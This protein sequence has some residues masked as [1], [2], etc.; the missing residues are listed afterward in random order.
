MYVIHYEGGEIYMKI[1][2]PNHDCMIR[3]S[4][5]VKGDMLYLY[6]KGDFKDVMY[7]LTYMVYGD[8]ECYYCHR[9]LRRHESQN[10]NRKYFSK[11][12][13]DHLIP[14]DFGGPTLPNNMRPACTACNSRKGN[15]FEDEYLEFLRIQDIVMRTG[16]QELMEKFKQEL[17]ERQEKRRKGDIPC[18]PQ[19]W[20]A[21]SSLKSMWVNYMVG[22]KKGGSYAQMVSDVE[23]YGCLIKTITCTANNVLVDGFNANLVS[24]FLEVPAII[25]PVDNMIHCGYPY[26]ERNT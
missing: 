24:T 10:D 6:K 14:Q 2:L 9:K 21:D 5:E 8:D 23:N 19:E 3:D 11:I 26:G 22:Q 25:I 13:M 15:M 12:S 1:P 4:A 20:I 17:F 16:K 18:I 7:A